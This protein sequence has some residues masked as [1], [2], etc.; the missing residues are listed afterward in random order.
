MKRH[1]RHKGRRGEALAERELTRQG[2]R[3]LARNL[4]FREAELDL[5]ALDG[6]TLCFVEVR[7]RA[8]AALGSAEESVDARKRRRI[9]RAAQRV[10]ASGTLPHHDALRFDVVA[11]DTSREPPEVRIVRDAFYADWR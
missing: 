9:V 4:H 3:V 11:V 7:L 1:N 10:L 6:R 5:L 8:G 2:Y